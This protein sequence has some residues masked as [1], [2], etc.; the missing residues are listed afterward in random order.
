MRHETSSSDEETP[1]FFLFFFKV[2]RPFLL[3]GCSAVGLCFHVCFSIYCHSKAFFS[4]VPV[5]MMQVCF[6]LFVLIF[7]HGCAFGN[8]LTIIPG[9]VVTVIVTNNR[10]TPF[11]IKSCISLT[12]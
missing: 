2:V 12:Q 10:D 9:L 1:C 6:L 4:C 7:C 5:K 11:V 3:I 8:G